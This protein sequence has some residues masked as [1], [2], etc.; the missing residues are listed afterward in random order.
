MKRAK[1][2]GTLKPR[3]PVARSPLLRKGGPHGKSTAAKRRQEQ[4]EL[5]K[6]SRDPD[7]ES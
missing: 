6:Q 5:V 4:V 1:Q 3:N 2:R 7:P